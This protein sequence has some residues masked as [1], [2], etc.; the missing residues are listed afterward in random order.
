MPPDAPLILV[1]D[2]EEPIRRFLRAALSSGAYRVEEAATG[3]QGLRK[4][5][6]SPPDLVILDLGLPDLDGTEVLQRLREW[7]RSPILV[8]S[9]RDHE[10]QKVAALDTGADDYLTK[11]FGTGELLA[12]VRVALRHAASAEA[13]EQ[14]A[15]LTMGDLSIDLAER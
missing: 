12:R 9:A 5:V 8:L 6:Q 11:P 7:L 13:G 3:E 14:S 10:S 2:D 15:R 1:I 4:A